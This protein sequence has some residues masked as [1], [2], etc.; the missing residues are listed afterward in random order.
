MTRQMK[1]LPLCALALVLA[2]CGCGGKAQ[3]EQADFSVQE[4]MAELT[5][6]ASIDE[7]L[8]LEEADMLD[9]F[10]IPAESMAD[11]AAQTCS[12]GISAQ[13]I[14][15]VKAADEDSAGTVEEKLQA[16]LDNWKAEMEN[17]LPDQYDILSQCRVQRDGLYV[18][19]I[20]HPEHEALEELYR[21]WAEGGK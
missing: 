21:G 4:A 2:L 8:A 10:G 5:Q 1:A 13:E 12:N 16:R 19:L 20:V 7:P 3:P 11:F 9:Y 15:L 17:Y 14:V 18:A 6:T